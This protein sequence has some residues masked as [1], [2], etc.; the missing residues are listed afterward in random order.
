[1]SVSRKLPVKQVNN[2]QGL[3]D[4]L[5]AGKTLKLLVLADDRSNS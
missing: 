2:R 3:E 1:M 4:G 5:G